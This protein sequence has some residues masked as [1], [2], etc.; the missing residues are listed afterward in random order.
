MKMC[1]KIIVALLIVMS[2]S[3]VANADNLVIL[4]TNDTHSQIDPTDKDKGGVL[5]RK[6]LIDSV[7]G[8][9]IMCC[10]LMPAMLCKAPFIS[11]CLKVRSSSR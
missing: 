11:T 8:L 1:K 5:R 2:V 10:L 3:L 7:R 4:H 6:A 9:I